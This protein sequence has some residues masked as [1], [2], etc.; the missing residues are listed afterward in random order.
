MLRRICAVY[1]TDKGCWL[2][3]RLRSLTLPAPF[4]GFR[5]GREM[6]LITADTLK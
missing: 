2:L 5:I 4:Q 1:L 6:V 3:S